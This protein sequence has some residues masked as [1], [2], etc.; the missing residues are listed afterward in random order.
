MMKKTLL[1]V[2]FLAGI[3]FLPSER[4]DASNFVEVYRN[5]NNYHIYIDSTS[6]EDKGD[7]LLVW[8][9]Y[10]PQT[11]EMEKKKREYGQ[12]YSH[13]LVQEAFK[14]KHRELQSLWIIDYATDGSVINQTRRP[15]SVSGYEQVVPNSIGDVLW[16]AVMRLSGNS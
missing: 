8:E 15:Y 10:I 9:K 4:A 3:L 11:V 14:K 13:M 16:D 1:S 7:Y 5:D 12:K 6:I 2:L